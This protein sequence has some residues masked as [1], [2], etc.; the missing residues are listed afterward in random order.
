MESMC[1]YRELETPTIKERW[2]EVSA[3]LARLM[4]WM[5]LREPWVAEPDA[6]FLT[7]LFAVIDKA[8]SPDF[9]N[10]LEQGENTARMAEVLA[11]M[12]SSRF[13]RVLEMLD[14]RNKGLLTRLTLGLGRLGGGARV[15]ADLFY[16]R[17]MLIHRAELL[18]QVLSPKRCQAIASS[19]ALVQQVRE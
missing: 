4:E 9:A 8:E 1:S 7:L 6:E 3:A 18:G 5:D 16:E 2:Q 17:L 15:F 19:I 13:L 12:S 14:R 11:L 10:K